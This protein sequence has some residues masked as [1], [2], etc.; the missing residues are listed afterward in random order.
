MR[1]HR[2]LVKNKEPH[3]CSP[4]LNRSMP[5]HRRRKFFAGP[6]KLHPASRTNWG[7]RRGWGRQARSRSRARAD[8]R[9]RSVVSGSSS[10]HGKPSPWPRRRGTA[11]AAGRSPGDGGASR[12][13]LGCLARGSSPCD[14]I[15]NS[16]MP[17]PV[18]RLSTSSDELALTRDQ[19]CPFDPGPRPATRKQNSCRTR[20][21]PNHGGSARAR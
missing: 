19:T 15:V 2:I 16:C 10:C 20:K 12:A 13:E 18:Q 11:A 5:G 8:G 7:N 14:V 9:A 1:L 21:G 6:P 17:W 3:P 4:L